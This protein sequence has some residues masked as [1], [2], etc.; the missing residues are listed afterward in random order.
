M[1]QN[2]PLFKYEE[3][4]TEKNITGLGGLLLYCE[5]FKA[6]KLDTL[7][8]RSLKVKANKQGYRDEQII[9]ALILLNLAGGESVSDIEILEKDEGF[10]QILRAMELR[11]TCGRRR[12]RIKRRWRRKEKNTVASPSS[13]FRYLE[14]FHDEEEEKKRKVGKAF[15]PRANKYLSRFPGLNSELVSFAHKRKTLKG[16][17]LDMDATLAATNKRRALYSYKGCQSYQPFNVWCYELN[18]LLHTEFRDGNVP[19]GYE[20][21]RM[22]E[23]SLRLLP[24]GVEEIYVRSDTAGYQHE[25]LKYCDE[26]KNERFGRIR[27]AIGCDVTPGFKESI[28]RDRDI[29]WSAINSGAEKEREESYQEWAEICYVPSELGRSKKGREY[30]YIAVREELVQRVLPGM[31]DNLEL[32][33]PTMEMCH[34]RYKVTA[35]VTNIEWQGEEIV[36]WYRQRCG[37]SE[38]VHSIM[39]EDLA[40][41]RFPS[42][43]FGENACWWWI[44]VLAL[45]IQSMMK[46]LVFGKQWLKKRMK[47]VRFQIINIPGRIVKGSGGKSFIIRIAH[48]H[49]LVNFL[50]GCRERIMELSYIPSG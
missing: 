15:I 1:P 18:M 11:G 33:F 7:I 4:N 32:P 50:N 31:E 44:M 2:K 30:R 46:Q 22:L 9:L 40:G 42:S 16:V 8:A 21:L 37:K 25:I 43:D 38:E 10:C 5:L 14:H 34:K 39:K 29:E 13:I 12:E 23:E 27:F 17:T 24:E 45:N 35:L 36:H 19:A 49:P 41:G 28:L 20:Q 47:S 3:E 26:G 6:L 48:G